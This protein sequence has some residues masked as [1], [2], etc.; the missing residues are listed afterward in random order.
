MFPYYEIT[1]DLPTSVNAS[2]T[3]GRNKKGGHIVRSGEY[4][5]WIHTASAQYRQQFRAGV[6]LKFTG[7]LRVDYIFIWNEKSKGK[8]S[9]DISNREKVLSDF[10]QSKFF[11]NDKQIDEQHHYR[12]ITKEGFDRVLLRVYEIPD[13]R[14]DDPGLIFNPKKETKMSE[15]K[16]DETQKPADTQT[17]NKPDGEGDGKTGEGGA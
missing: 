1:L 17:E 14:F 5:R 10:L 9:S 2:H 8:D 3:V 4:T 11:D 13:R 15:E 12:R 6:G 16:K 7:R